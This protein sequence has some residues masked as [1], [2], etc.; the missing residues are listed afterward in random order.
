M[1]GRFLRNVLLKGLGIFIILNLLWTVVDSPKL[2]TLSLYD[3]LFR[4]RERFPYGENSVESYNLSL[5][6]IYAMFESLRLDAVEVPVNEFRVLVIGDS[7]TWGTLL[8]P[9]ETLAGQLDALNLSTSD[10]RRVRFYNL[11]YPTLSLTKDLMILDEGMDYMPDL[12]LWPVTLESFP[13]NRQLDSPIAA[14]NLGRIQSLQQEYGLDLTIPADSRTPL[15]RF[16]ARTIVGQRRALADLLRLQV[17]GAM[18]SATGID[19]VYPAEY[20][21]AARDLEPDATFNGWQG[22][23]LD[24]SQISLDVLQAGIQMAGSI[25]V[26]L[27]NEPV[28]V[29][30]GKN[31]DIRYNFYYP[32]WAY[33]DYRRILSDRSA[34]RGWNYI[35]LWNAVPQERFTNSAIHLDPAG[36]SLEVKSLLPQI[37]GYW[38]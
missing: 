19:Q 22:P 28:L 23:N 10:G 6:N 25:P 26:V 36:V 37:E 7:S 35:D 11:G 16:Y 34:S 20:T 1:N 17:Y 24:E 15:Q 21:P 12:I 30:S 5:N 2:G 3:H 29:S 32:R 9:E 4:G 13:R 33:D 27:I 8:R 31:S 38:R 18:W 14:N